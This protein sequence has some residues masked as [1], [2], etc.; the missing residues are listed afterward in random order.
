VPPERAAT[1]QQ[2]RAEKVFR[3]LHAGAAEMA[4]STRYEVDY[5]LKWNHERQVWEAS[6]GFAYD[7]AHLF[8]YSRRGTRLSWDSDRISE[9]G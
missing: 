8:E 5:G 2:E 6:D 9:G 7:G 3:V 1:A 4:W